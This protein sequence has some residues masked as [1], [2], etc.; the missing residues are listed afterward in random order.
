M[1]GFLV[2]PSVYE[3]FSDALPGFVARIIDYCLAG[4]A[5]LVPSF[6]ISRII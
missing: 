6:L 3:A 2:K 5:Y 1:I 4:N